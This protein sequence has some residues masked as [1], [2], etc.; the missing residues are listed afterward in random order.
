MKNFALIGAAGYI[1]PRHMRAIKDTGNRLSAAG[2]CGPG[3]GLFRSS[4][5]VLS[6]FRKRTP[7]LTRT[8]SETHRRYWPLRRAGKCAATSGFFL[9]PTGINA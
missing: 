7:K 4:W 5:A 6:G 9:A 8:P 3:A 1:A 2:A